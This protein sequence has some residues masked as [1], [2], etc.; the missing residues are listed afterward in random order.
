[1]SE[2]HLKVEFI[3][4]IEA[5]WIKRFHFKQFQFQWPYLVLH[6]DLNN[7]TVV[8]LLEIWV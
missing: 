1:M 7:V 6:L 5:P 8:S 4:Y 3:L 2:N